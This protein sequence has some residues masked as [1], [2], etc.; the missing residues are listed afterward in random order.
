MNDGLAGGS[1]IIT[2]WDCVVCHAEGDALTGD[3][4]SNYHQKDGVQLKDTDTGVA[5]SNW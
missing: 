5:Y 2:K 1:E 3:T 4:D